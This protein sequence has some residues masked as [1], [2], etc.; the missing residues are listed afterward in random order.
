MKKNK[1]NEIFL[2]KIL[3]FN[4][5]KNGSLNNT[6]YLTHLNHSIEK[7]NISNQIFLFDNNHNYL[8][9][10]KFSNKK[11]P[12]IE[13]INLQNIKSVF[14]NSYINNIISTSADY[15]KNLK[16][17][18]G[19]RIMRNLNPFQDNSKLYSKNAHHPFETNIK[20]ENN[21]IKND[22]IKKIMSYF[23]YNK[24]NKLNS[25]KLNVTKD[26]INSYGNNNKSNSNEKYNLYKI[27]KNFKF[28]LYKEKNIPSS[29]ININN[30][31]KKRKQSSF[32]LKLRHNILNNEYNK[33]YL[34][35][36]LNEDTF[37]NIFTNLEI[38][39]YINNNSEFPD[40]FHKENNNKS[41]QIS[42]NKSI[43]NK[44]NNFINDN[45]VTLNINI[46]ELKDIK[47][48]KKI[49]QIFEHHH[50][51]F[52]KTNYKLNE[53]KINNLNNY[54]NNK[55]NNNNFNKK[56]IINNE[57]INNKEDKNNNNKMIIN[58]IYNL[59]NVISRNNFNNF[60]REKK[61]INNKYEDKCIGTLY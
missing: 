16:N 2:K 48:K 25:D 14:L 45:D 21:N 9:N 4:K 39:K 34:E 29:K 7:K 58:K 41:L 18:N 20:F 13:K 46:S 28:N 40:I 37:N 51:P 12:K 19:F 38:K 33:K 60:Y 22:E 6:S 15:H 55:F 1:E 8:N 3:H 56:I 24:E 54:K 31:I 43:N 49:N 23:S 26:A 53:N 47:I 30:F 42:K 17:K 35:K 44:E 52:N 27:N 10:S 11:S 50:I 5:I 32:K 61:L 57:N 59:Q 36:F